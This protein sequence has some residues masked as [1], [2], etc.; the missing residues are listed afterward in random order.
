MDEVLFGKKKPKDEG[1]VGLAL[2]AQDIPDV[3][4]SAP[5]A[6]GSP[7]SEAAARAID[8]P[9]RRASWRKLMLA[10][11]AADHPLTMHE[12]S[13]RTGLPI[14]VVCARLPE[15]EPVWIERQKRAGRSHVK[16]S[17][18][19]DTFSLTAVGRSRLS[20]PTSLNADGA[21]SAGQGAA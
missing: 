17:L 1:V 16:P 14:N 4:T 2:F 19:V 9:F 21:R 18:A 5:S 8:G 12:L 20:A 11:G 13:E 10:L 3:R 15:L 7:S 6:P